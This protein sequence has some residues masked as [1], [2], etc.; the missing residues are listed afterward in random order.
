M[1]PSKL[2]LTNFMCYRGTT[3]ALDFD[4]FDVACITGENGNG[5]SAL[6]ESITWVIWGKTKVLFSK[7][8]ITK[9]ENDM[10]VDFEFFIDYISD[11]S[12]LNNKYKIIRSIRT[13]SGGSILDLQQFDGSNY[14]SISG[15]TI[16]ETQKQIINLVNMDYETFVNTSYLMQGNADR[17]TTSKP[18][19]R[20]DILSAIL[21]LD[22]YQNLAD[23]TRNIL[24]NTDS[25]INANNILVDRTRLEISDLDPGN[26][27][28]DFIEKEIINLNQKI[29][30]LNN[31]K[32]Q[33][34]QNLQLNNKYLNEISDFQTKKQLLSSSYEN[35]INMIN[36]LNDLLLKD[37]ELLI[38]SDNILDKYN[39]AITKQKELDD[40]YI[41][42]SKYQDINNQLN[43]LQN[44]LDFRMN[45]LEIE[46][47][48]LSKNRNVLDEKIN[49]DKF[50]L[51]DNQKNL[52]DYRSEIIEL[53]KLN[54]NYLNLITKF[55]DEIT[56]F[57]NKLVTL[58]TSNKDH[59]NKLDLLQKEHKTCPLCKS[60]LNEETKKFIVFDLNNKIQLNIKDINN[61]KSKLDESEKEFFYIQDKYKNITKSLTDLNSTINLVNNDCIRIKKEIDANI[62]QISNY[63]NLIND[64]KYLYENDIK[65]KVNKNKIWELNLLLDD[66]KFDQDRFNTLI[67]EVPDFKTESE[68]NLLLLNQAEERIKENKVK[69][70]TLNS[71]SLIIKEQIKVLEKNIKNINQIINS[72]NIKPDL[73]EN[74]DF[75][76]DD[77]KKTLML[78]Q[79]SFDYLISKK[80]YLDEILNNNKELYIKSEDL[81]FLE[82]SFSRNGIQA[83]IIENV[84]PS[85]EL[86]ANKLLSYLTENKLSVNLQIRK[87]RRLKNTED[88]SQ[89]IDIIIADENGAVREYE[90]YS[91]GESFRIDFAIRIAL[92]RLV[93]L[94]S[95]V[96]SPILFI[97]EGFGSQDQIGQDR[98]REAIQE[99]S[100]SE[101]YKFKKIIVIT[102]LESLKESFGVALEVSKNES[103]SYFSLN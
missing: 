87:G 90:T 71:D 57:K 52:S 31:Q 14:V 38:Q 13:K 8:L 69:L 96:R 2:R 102:H 30:S 23:F 46:L 56:Q 67:N 66:L 68:K 43:T 12:E 45:E 54:E 26:N 97:D 10:L 4:Q 17:F 16:P 7:D 103:S 55:T 79:N 28:T 58:K 47:R 98:L 65:I 21:N 48:N 73:S 74:I 70:N 95:G 36:N 24:R 25:S 101:N 59:E 94:R 83:L 5:K 22:Y 6:L 78:K 72:L 82:I 61:N 35:N 42:S 89:E 18:D 49:Q 34:Q 50:L 75:S 29:E 20:K 39:D 88:F 44:E 37:N 76:L 85:L 41:A 1:I 15:D 27:G 80:N 91:G 32:L 62:N 60:D 51:E 64:T 99:I 81:K 11:D 40:L 33:L 63:K 19:E 53:N 84:L 100:N 92:S 77:L 3:E 86:E 93:S 9:G